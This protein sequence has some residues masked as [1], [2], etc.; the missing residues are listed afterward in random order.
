MKCKA[1]VKPILIIAAIFSFC[2]AQNLIPLLKTT[3]SSAELIGYY[4]PTGFVNVDALD[5]LPHEVESYSV[6]S[7]ESTN[8]FSNYLGEGQAERELKEKRCHWNRYSNWQGPSGFAIPT[9]PI[10]NNKIEFL[11]TNSEIY[12]SAIQNTL[13]EIT[14]S[15][16]SPIIQQLVKVDLENDGVDEVIIVASNHNLEGFNFKTSAK[17]DYSVVL[18]RKLI[19]GVVHTFTLA[20]SVE[21]QDME[22]NPPLFD[23]LA[24][25]NFQIVLDIDRDGIQEIILGGFGYEFDLINVYTWQ[26]DAPVEV[27]NWG[28]GL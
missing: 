11:D 12:K 10:Q 16:N 27:I 6:Y 25:Y 22:S 19:A 8:G 26:N 24:R 2:Y 3:D 21:T 9:N 7:S 15:T 13:A 20:S 23:S 28:C 14:N 4:S 18:L 5:E 1:Q 17:G